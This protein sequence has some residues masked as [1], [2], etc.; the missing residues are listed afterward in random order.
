MTRKQGWLQWGMR[1]PLMPVAVGQGAWVRQRA[2]AV[3]P[4]SGPNDGQ[5]A[6][7]GEPIW[8]EVLGESTAAGVGAA[9]HADGLGGHLALALGRISGRPVRWRAIGRVGARLIDMRN[10]L[11]VSPPPANHIVVLACGVN[12]A[13]GFTGRIEWHREVLHFV[14]AM[15]ARRAR[16]VLLSEVP[17][18]S[19]FPG[20]PWPLSGMLALRARQLNAVL[21]MVGAAHPRARLVKLELPPTPHAFAADGF[22]PSTEGYRAWAGRLAQAVDTA[23]V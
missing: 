8:L 6:G 10:C 19:K 21:E 1:L 17:D 2:P 20:L 7:E 9:T 14:E 22:H 23:T 15:V 12:D 16:W 4:A 13:L 11:R 18:F 5:V 3:P